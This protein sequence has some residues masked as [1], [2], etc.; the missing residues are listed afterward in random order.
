M[1]DHLGKKSSD[2][3]SIGA[4]ST[5][6]SRVGW[7]PQDAWL[8]AFGDGSN[9]PIIIDPIDGLPR[10]ADEH[11]DGSAPAL[12]ED[13]FICMADE[14][15]WVPWMARDIA[16][17]TVAAGTPD[18][19]PV[20]YDESPTETDLP[21]WDD[22]G[23]PIPPPT[24]TFD[25]LR[26][27]YGVM[28]C[29][30]D[31]GSLKWPVRPIRQKCEHFMRQL[32]T[33]QTL[34]ST[35][36]PVIPLASFCRGFLIDG[37]PMSLADQAVWAC[38]RRSPRDL[39]TEEKIV[40]RV[41]KKIAQGKEKA[42]TPVFAAAPPGPKWQE[43]ADQ[44]RW[45]S[46]S[47]DVKADPAVAPGKTGR[48]MIYCPAWIVAE[49]TQCDDLCIVGTEWM[50]SEIF[51]NKHF[52]G[53]GYHTCLMQPHHLS[54][55]DTPP[56]EWLDNWPARIDGHL[57]LACENQP[58]YLAKSLRAGKTVIITAAKREHAMWYAALVLSE[59]PLAPLARAILPT[60]P[61]GDAYFNQR[62]PAT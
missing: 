2:I 44:Y 18:Y 39:V 26:K 36:G 8:D 27:A 62:Y 43:Q 6:E 51:S 22:E 33:D 32:I 19:P 24:Y 38:E 29:L 1:G 56:P 21:E 47:Y 16:R 48:L 25:Q 37:E 45:S 50:P 3:P 30:N 35:E 34:S 17:E 10:P 40:E 53:A 60:F 41:R 15:L 11:I 28:W 20:V 9:A 23:N 4:L 42:P 58:A 7:Q 61:E 12:T 52:P 31:D 46:I 14:R 57:A 54:G 55:M 13:S 49:K 59:T 5:E